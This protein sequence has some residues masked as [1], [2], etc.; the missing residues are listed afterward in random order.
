MNFSADPEGPANYD[1]RRTDD[2]ILSIVNVGAKIVYRLGTSIEHTKTKYFIHPPEDFNKW[3]RICIN[4]I[5]HYNQGWANGFH[6]GIKYWEIWNEPYGN[7][8][9]ESSKNA[10]WSGTHE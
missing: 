4:I 10:M 9:V 3:S 8:D 5:I 7:P 2:Y 6:Y 1:F